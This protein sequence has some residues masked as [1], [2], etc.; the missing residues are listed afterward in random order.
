[1]HHF[2][3]TEFIKISSVGTP[4]FSVILRPLNPLI[5]FKAVLLI[6]RE[7]P[8]NEAES[9]RSTKKPHPLANNHEFYPGHRRIT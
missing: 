4:R 1:M 7:S 5:Q 9:L 3:D 8:Y 2:P 6:Q